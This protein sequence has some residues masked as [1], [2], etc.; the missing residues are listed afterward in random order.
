MIDA[1][2]FSRNRPMQLH[3]L[4][5]SIEKYTNLSKIKVLHRY[6]DRYVEGLKQ[7]QLLHP[8][9]EFLE[10][11]GF[12][13]QVKSFLSKGEKHCTFF[14][15]DIVVKDE[16][17]FTHVC[18]VL[19]NNPPFLTFSL[20]LGT[21]LTK[22]Y[23]NNSQQQV[24]NGSINSG[25]FIWGWKGASHDWG[26]PLSV[27]GHVFRRA[28]LESWCNHLKFKNPNQFESVMQSIPST[29]A[30]QDYC[31]SYV[32]SKIVNTPVNRVQEEF[33]N[34]SEEVSIDDLYD[35]WLAGERLQFEK[36]FKILNDGAHMPIEIPR[37]LRG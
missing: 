9:V 26:Y 16:I 7:V 28:E 17:D 21:H 33:K 8:S 11:V 23:P 13:S 6:D 12:E 35:S 1:M 24:P 37:G 25:F 3:C 29:F 18:N 14:V 2:V 10:E 20:R 27:D 22:C 30:L 5:E 31:V 36:V 15:D 4:L 34:R 32:V 19:E